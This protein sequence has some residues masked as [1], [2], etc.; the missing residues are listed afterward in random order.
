MRR[1]FRRLPM[2]CIPRARAQFVLLIGLA[3]PVAAQSADCDGHASQLSVPV[4]FCVR[5]FADSIGAV[6]HLVV[7]P[8]G[9]LVAALNEAPGL[10]R[11][12]ASRSGAAADQVVRFGPGQRGTGVTWRNGWLYFAA[13]SGIVRYR[14]P[15]RS[16]APDPKGEWIARSL[17]VG[18]AGVAQ[19]AKAIAVGGDGS[20]Y[21]TIGAE[22]DNCQLRDRVPKSLGRWPCAELERRAGV[23][24]F[25]PPADGGHG[26]TTQRFA[27]GLRSASALA[28]DPS[29]D[30]LWAVTHGRELLGASGEWSDSSA[31]NQPAEMLEQLVQNGDYGWPYCQGSWARELTTLVRAPEYANQ[32]GIDCSLKTQPVMG[33]RGQWE[34]TAIAVVNTAAAPV[35]HPGLFIAFHGASAR[36]AA[37]AGGDFLMFV[38]LDENG[39]PAGDSRIIL[40]SSA[41]PGSLRP[42]GVAVAPD[43]SIYVSDDE[44]HRIVVIE[45]HPPKGR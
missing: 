35:P 28:I 4:G 10:V 19:T 43:G 33:F 27:T 2:S 11:F 5:L 21:L 22:T 15:A 1:R 17:P 3:A 45:P 36:M 30:R 9:Q 31:A 38:P 40:R 25:S 16:A 37:A 41:A 39:R 29:T 34:S 14:W 24:R 13:D 7:H 32:A 26:W 6:R 20:V 8:S 18:R 44:H 12:R 42:A 23:W